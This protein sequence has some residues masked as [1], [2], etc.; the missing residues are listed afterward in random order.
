ALAR[1]AWAGDSSYEVRAAAL[2]ALA[3]LDSAAATSA[4]REGLRT[5]SYRDA[6]QAAAISAVV[7]RPDSGLVADV[8]AIAGRQPLA[9][10]GLAALA[11]RGDGA[12][13]A[14]LER[15]LQDRRA[16]V[17]EWAREATGLN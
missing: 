12:A 13:R 7:D 3:R 16:W 8:E 14:A 10:Y 11:A 5:P 1:R 15:L 4:I 2:G 17:R 9:A 6:I